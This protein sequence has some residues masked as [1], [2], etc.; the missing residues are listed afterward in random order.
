MLRAIL[1]I[2]P[3][4][5]SVGFFAAALSAQTSGSSMAEEQRALISA[6]E[7]SERAEQRGNALRRQAESASNDADRF[8]SEAAALAARIQGAEA[9]IKAARARI[10][11]VGR[12]Q[13]QQRAR[14]AEKQ[15]PVIRLTAALQMM[16]RKPTALTLVEPRSLDELIYIRSIMSTVL[17]EIERRTASLREEV[18]QGEKLRAQSVRAIASLN[19]SQQRLSDRRKQLAGLEANKRITASQ[20]ANDAGIEQDRALALG[21]E[22][23]DIL[24][25]MDQIQ[26][27]GAVRESLADLDGPML[28]PGQGRSAPVSGKPRDPDIASA[29]R[30]PVIGE[31]VTGLGEISDSG[32]RSRGLT[33]AVDANAQIV[34]PAAGRIAYSGRYRGYGNILIIEHEAGWTSLITNMANTSVDV[35]E[36][37]VQGAPVGRSGNDE[38]TVTVELRRNG[39]PI[40]IA[41][42]V[43]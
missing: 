33:I 31:I 41:A 14:L 26:R 30:L 37:V 28:R 20:F 19:E 32:Y 7:Q 1:M 11:I 5:I 17:P 9:D 4:I 42:L 27:S 15:G 8:G 22:A 18:Q 38:P 29:Y 3:L 2:L 35:G 24:D 16:T 36:E 34:A 21:E 40:D 23:R 13:Q 6:R 25:L 39:R 12:L 10:S 43:G